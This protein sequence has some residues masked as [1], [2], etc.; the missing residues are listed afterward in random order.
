LSKSF[1]FASAL[2]SS[3]EKIGR[4]ADVYISD[5]LGGLGPYYKYFGIVFIGGSL[6]AGMDGQN[7]MEAARLGAAIL[8]GPHVDSLLETY[9]VLKRDGAVTIVPDA[10][11]LAEK[12]TSL[13]SAPALLEEMKHRAAATA[14]RETASLDRAREKLRQKFKELGLYF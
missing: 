10:D 5:V 7:P 3:K 1:G 14:E 13:L 9:G 12:V 4:S 11:A 2:E 6:L 8:S